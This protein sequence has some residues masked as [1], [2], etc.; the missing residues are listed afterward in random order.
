M[1]NSIIQLFAALADLD[2]NQSQ[3]HLDLASIPSI[4]SILT[5]PDTEIVRYTDEIVKVNPKGKKQT[6]IFMLTT[7]AIYNLTSQ[8]GILGSK[9]FKIQR[10]IEIT[11]ILGISVSRTG[12][13]FAIHVQDERDYLLISMRRALLVLAIAKEYMKLCD[14]ILK[15]EVISED[16]IDAFVV[17][18][19]EKLVG[20]D[21]DVGKDSDVGNEDD[22]EEEEKNTGPDLTRKSRLITNA[23]RRIVSQ[24]KNRFQ[25]DG[26][27]LDLSYILSNVIAMGFPS[28]DFDGMYRNPYSEVYRFLESRHR[29]YYKVYNLCS[30]RRYDIAKFHRRVGLFP[31]DDHNCPSM[32][33]MVKFCEDAHMWLSQNPKHIIAVHCKAGKGRTGLMISCYL[34]YSGVCETPDDALSL[35]ASKRTI[36]GKGVTIPSQIRFVHYFGKYITFYKDRMF[37]LPKE[38]PVLKLT[39]IEFNSIPDLGGG[40]CAPSFKIFSQN[41]TKIFDSR[42]EMKPKSIKKGKGDIVLDLKNCVFAGTSKF[43]FRSDD[44]DLFHFWLNT[45]FLPPEKEV[46][47]YNT[48]VELKKSIPSDF[49]FKDLVVELRKNEIDRACK[50]KHCKIYDKDFS[51][52]LHMRLDPSGLMASKESQG[53]TVKISVADVYEKVA[54]LEDELLKERHNSETLEAN[55]EELRDQHEL[56]IWE[57]REFRDLLRAQKDKDHISPENMELFDQMVDRRLGLKKDDLQEIDI[58]IETIEELENEE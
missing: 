57:M 28:D 6:R 25:E 4:R 37:A 27:D 9:S 17:R 39:K 51:I 40:G 18:T 2:S 52:T 33:T 24:K 41:G 14:K 43:K 5:H 54:Y 34:L 1:E 46:E 35:F 26:F 45:R 23:F 7:E 21:S 31:F 22:D 13:T 3:D 48:S 36:N 29:D 11:S 38:A 44:Q 53:G 12:S 8:S 10:R 30:E 58:P 55:L 47:V 42:D 49:E 56:L 32:E 20:R 50:D 19:R 15:V 16:T